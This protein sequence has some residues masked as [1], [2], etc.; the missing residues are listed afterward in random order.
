MQERKKKR[1]VIASVLKPV[2]EPRMYAKLGNTLA[3]LGHE[4][5]ITAQGVSRSL[6]A[7]SVTTHSIGS[8]SRLSWPRVCAPLRSFWHW[9]LLKPNT[10][11]ISTHE[12]LWVGILARVFLRVTLVYDVQENYYR[13]ILYTNAFPLWLR[14]PLAAYVRAKEW[15]CSFFIHHFLLAEEVYSRQLPFIKSRYSVL[16]NRFCRADV[17]QQN[18]RCGYRHLLFTGTIADTTGVWQAI[19]IASRLHAL[20]NQFTLTIIGHTPHSTMLEKLKK[21]E[22]HYDFIK[23]HISTQPV[24]HAVIKN[25]I[26]AA[27]IGIIAYPHNKSTEGRVPT[28][29]FEYTALKL[30]IL[31]LDYQSFSSRIQANGGILFTQATKPGQLLSMLQEDVTASLMEE[32][33]WESYRKHL[34]ELFPSN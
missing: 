7:S 21:I 15:L 22:Q 16:E 25:A 8:F 9:A 28:K 24:S 33:W 29:Y 32:A 26:L 3:E 10:L 5:H 27:D 31:A 13:N 12:L 30:R 23:L 1:I 11:I 4:V 2:D 6:A 18:N 20:D 19:D 14:A 34:A 17:A